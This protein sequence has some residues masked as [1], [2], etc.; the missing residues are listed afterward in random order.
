M[1]ESLKKLQEDFVSSYIRKEKRERLLFELNNEKRRYS[2]LDR[3]CHHTK[4]LLDERKILYAG[5]RLEKEKVYF[6]LLKNEGKKSCILLSPDPYLDCKEM[7]LEEAVKEMFLC[8]DACILIGNDFAL[9][10]E[11]AMK[12][13]TDRYLLKRK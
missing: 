4:E 9:M 2:S 5:T 6:D 12:G 1:D 10:Q 11:E 8:N 13:G 7:T 3:F